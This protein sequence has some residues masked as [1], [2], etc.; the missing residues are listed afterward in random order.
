MRVYQW[1]YAERFWV[2]E[3]VNEIDQK[4]ISKFTP[5]DQLDEAFVVN[6]RRVAGEKG[7]LG[8]R[9]DFSL[10]TGFSRIVSSR[11]YDALGELLCKYGRFFPLIDADTSDKWYMYRCT[12]ICDC[13]DKERSNMVEVEVNGRKKVIINKALFK[14]GAI[15]GDVFVIPELECMGHQIYFT[16]IVKSEVE[17]FG[18]K[19]L[20]LDDPEGKRRT[21]IS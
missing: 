1:S 13:L 20:V 5:V 12:N 9:C 15:N 3:A 10:T 4:R 17:K 8:H 21:W 14:K 2:F 16:D 6:I 11:A 19:G 18:L 7:E